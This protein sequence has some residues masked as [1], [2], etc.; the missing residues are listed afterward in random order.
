M[1]YYTRFQS[2]FLRKPYQIIL[3][4]SQHY[5]APQETTELHSG[6][7][8]P[9]SENTS[10]RAED[11]PS[12][13]RRRRTRGG[14]TLDSNR[15]LRAGSRRPRLWHTR[16]TMRQRDDAPPTPCHLLHP[17]AEEGKIRHGQTLLYRQ[18]DE[19]ATGTSSRSR[20]TPRT[21]IARPEAT[22]P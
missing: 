15:H 3:K 2:F 11:A 12:T 21:S 1:V 13:H 19:P 10:A 5:K 7:W 18:R 17:E 9:I 6:P 4:K 16:M 8:T 14:L 22:S 20:R